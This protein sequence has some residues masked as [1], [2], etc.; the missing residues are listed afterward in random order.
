MACPN[1][2]DGFVMISLELGAALAM[3]RLTTAEQV[4]VWEVVSRTYGPAK[5]P[6]AAISATD[7]ARRTGLDRTFLA[8]GLRS[9]LDSGI[10]AEG[11]ER[12]EYKLQ[13]NYDRWDRSAHK[14]SDES[15]RA[16]REY[17]RAAVRAARSYP[18]QAPPDC[19]NT[20]TVGCG[21]I[22]TVADSGCGNTATVGVAILPQS[23]G[24]TATPI[25]LED[26]L[27]LKEQQQATAT[28]DEDPEPFH[29]PVLPMT[30]AA[31]APSPAQDDAVIVARIEAFIEASGINP[32]FFECK[33]PSLVAQYPARWVEKAIRDAVPK[34]NRSQGPM[35]LVLTMLKSWHECDGPEND[36]IYTGKKPKLHGGPAA[37]P[38]A[39]PDYLKDADEAVPA[40]P[41]PVE[42]SA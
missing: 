9:L 39:V 10:L 24:N 26:S 20:A 4:I 13:K 7:L 8:K 5:A 36:P 42:K 19:G 29:P 22:A 32:Q 15:A 28:E 30:K 14:E 27:D 1:T 11:K 25:L 2:E 35:G 34:S 38:N 41:R 33:I 37:V 6:L 3:A 12:G 31:P 21:D 40:P 18:K 23:C 16:R 17:A